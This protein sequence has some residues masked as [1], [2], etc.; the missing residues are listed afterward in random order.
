MHKYLSCSISRLPSSEAV[1]IFRV[2]ECLPGLHPI[3]LHWFGTGMNEPPSPRLPFAR[4]HARLSR[5][6]NLSSRVPMPGP[7]TQSGQ[8]VA[9]SVLALADTMFFS[10]LGR[11]HETTRLHQDCWRWRRCVAVCRAGAKVGAA[12]GRISLRRQFEQ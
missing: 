2:S 5:R 12:G 7:V 10:E 1:A 4:R 8:Q 9:F 11:S 6:A 3:Y